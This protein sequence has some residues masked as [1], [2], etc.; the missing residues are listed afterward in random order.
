MARFSVPSPR[1]W[2]PAS[3][4]LGSLAVRPPSTVGQGGSGRRWAAAA[5]RLFLCSTSHSC[6]WWQ[7]D[8]QGLS[9]SL[10]QILR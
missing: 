4:P 6:R 3:Q 7:R 10:L 9:R 1:P 8:A 2:S 5:A